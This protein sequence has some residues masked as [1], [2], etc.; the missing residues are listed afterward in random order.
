MDKKTLNI[1]QQNAK[2]LQELKTT[3]WIIKKNRSRKLFSSSFLNQN[4]K[5]QMKQ[6]PINQSKNQIQT[7]KRN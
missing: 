5:I 4:L 6:Q 2:Y 3:I 7:T 1:K